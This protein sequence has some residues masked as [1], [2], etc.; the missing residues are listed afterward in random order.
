MRSALSEEGGAHPAATPEAVAQPDL[1]IAD[2]AAF[3]ERLRETLNGPAAAAG[4]R[5]QLLNLGMLA[6]RFGDR[7]PQ[8]LEKIDQLT[9]L[10]VARRLGP[11]DYF[12]KCGNGLYVLVFDD[13]PESEARLKCALFAEELLAR[14]I[15]AAPGPDE[16]VVATAA[17]RI[18]GSMDLKGYSKLDLLQELLS[19]APQ[20]VARPQGEA[21]DLRLQAIGELTRL[22][23]AE[24]AGR[25]GGGTPDRLARLLPLLREAENLLRTGPEAPPRPAGTGPARTAEPMPRPDLATVAELIRRAEAHAA[26]PH[27]EAAADAEGDIVFRYGP[28]WKAA[29][30]MVFAYRCEAGLKQRSRLLLGERMMPRDP[31]PQ[32]VTA[33]DLLVLRKAIVDIRRCVADRRTVIVMLS[34][35][36]ATLM[37]PA[38]R[39]EFVALLERMD[40]PTRQ[41]IVWE[42]VEPVIGL[43]N[44][45]VL[46]TVALLRAHG[47]AVLLQLPADYTHFG[48]FS[49][50]GLHAVGFDAGKLEPRDLDRQARLFRSRAERYGLKSYVR[51]L[52]SPTQVEAAAGHGFDYLDG[53]AVL[54]PVEAPGPFR[55]VTLQDICRPGSAMARA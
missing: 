22:V 40:V 27:R 44:G 37:R 18:D 29:S 19:A 36:H 6:Q 10:T 32:L 50:I 11:R 16:V 7:W 12:T 43:S 39:Q 13:L 9:E 23:A 41:S 47:R 35:H 21:L 53:P 4:G 46:P 26:P 30:S 49:S 1:L 25:A 2:R 54:N 3:E 5:V 8:I 28:V 34:V 17:A 45:N 51:G 15:G 24:L 38:A 31:D 48:D 52:L 42:I 55:E 33:Y 20:H 14:L